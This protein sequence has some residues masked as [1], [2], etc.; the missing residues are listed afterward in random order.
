MILSIG[1]K[2]KT[3]ELFN[4]KE[5]YKRT[6]NEIQVSLKMFKS[7]LFRV[8]PQRLVSLWQTELKYRLNMAYPPGC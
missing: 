1:R 5:F 7:K 2:Y 6:N 4:K 3:E 8:C